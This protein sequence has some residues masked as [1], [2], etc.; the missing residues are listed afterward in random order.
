MLYSEVTQSYIYIHSL[1]CI[2]SHHGL[3]QEPGFSSLCYMIGPHCS[4]ILNV[5][6]AST[7]LKLP[8]YPSPTLANTSLFFLSVSLFLF[9]R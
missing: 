4:S 1:P 6:F 5:T 9:C 2:I 8:G 3:S 7:N